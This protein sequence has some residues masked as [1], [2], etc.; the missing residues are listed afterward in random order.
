[1]T[2]TKAEDALARLELFAGL[3]PADLAHLASAMRER[4]L[5]AG[6][7][8]CGRGDAGD[9]LFVVLVG[10][11][12]VSVLTPEGR[13]LSMRIA[14]PGEMVGEI[15]VFDG[16][17]RTT[18]MTAIEPARVA[19][20]PAEAFFKALALHPEIARNALK[21]LC[22]RVRDTTA[23]LESIALYP[24]EQRLARLLLLSLGGVEAAPGRRVAV[25]LNLSQTE[26]A[27]LLGAT[28]SKVNLALGKLEEAGALRRTSDRLFC[29]RDKLMRIAEA[30]N[31]RE[32]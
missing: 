31:A 7:L 22:R 28:R 24:I 29:D 14:G 11:L 4:A 21:M 9:R 6:E 23:Q 13:E 25:A 26:I 16:G 32:A 12:R 8:L 17:A 15:A 27:Q 19:A 2:S 10:R 18:D 20:L 5:S 1:V 3:A 30:A